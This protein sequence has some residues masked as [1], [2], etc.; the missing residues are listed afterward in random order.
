MAKFCSRCGA[1]ATGGAFC[2]QCGSALGANPAP[3]QSP[4]AP[5]ISPAAA[6]VKSGGGAGKVLLIVGGVVFLFVAVGVAGVVYVGY[7]A[8]QKIESLKK[9]YVDTPASD[10]AA[11]SGV[12][13]TPGAIPAGSVRGGCPVLPAEE[14]SRVLGIAVERVT[15]K[16]DP[17]E[18]EVCDFFV[19]DAERSRLA[20]AEIT[21]AIGG[22]SHTSDDKQ[23]V[24][25][26]Q[27]LAR[28][29]INAFGSF[30]DKGSKEPM[31]EL[32]VMRS[33]GQAAFEKVQQTQNV[34]NS[35]SAASFQDV[36][37]VGDKAVIAPAGQSAFVLKGDTMFTLNFR[38]F[39]GSDKAVAMAK[40]VAGRL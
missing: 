35:V 14:A 15:Q 5:P 37:G 32:S 23:G 8:K 24:E 20:Q 27:N 34:A 7:R 29:A 9:E 25:E 38:Y 6:P 10:S 36:Q 21:K 11:N 1:P 18:G 3:A 19:S 4:A 40:E 33:G 30:E 39:P 13:T 2:V 22:M 31:L 28:G 16:E 26:A 17:T 12:L